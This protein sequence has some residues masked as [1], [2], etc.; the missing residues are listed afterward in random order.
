MV[1]FYSV[2]P[3]G[4]VGMFSAGPFGC[5]VRAKVNGATGKRNFRHNL[6]RLVDLSLMWIGGPFPSQANGSAC[7]GSIGIACPRRSCSQSARKR[8]TPFSTNE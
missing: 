7:S 3:A 5:R 4:L 1:R 6:C 2:V 8:T